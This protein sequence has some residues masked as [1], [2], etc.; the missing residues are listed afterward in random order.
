MIIHPIDFRYGT[1]EMKYIWT[2]EYRL[3]CILRVEISLAQAESRLGII[4]VEAAET[5]TKSAAVVSLKRVKEIESE[6]GHEVMATVKALSEVS[7]SAGRW[8]HFGVSSSDV[9]DTATGLQLKAALKILDEKLRSLLSVLLTR[10]DETK[11]LVCIARTHGQHA[12]PTTY[13]M[14]FAIWASEISRHLDRITELLKRTAVGQ[15]TGAVGTMAAFGKKGIDIQKE[16]MNILGLGC[17][18]VSNQVISRDRYAEYIF[19]LANIATTMDKIGIELRTLQRTEIGEVAEA[20]GRKQIGSSAMPHKRNPVKS[21]QVCGLSRII[22]GM[23]EPALMN[24]TLWDERDL[25]NSSSERI[26]FPE[27]SV[28]TDHC[29]KLTTDILSTLTIN[30]DAVRENLHYLS[31]INLA[32]AV[33]TELTARGA[34]RQTA[35]D[36]IHD[37]CMKAFAEKK[38]LYDILAENSFVIQYLS[39]EEINSLLTPENYIGLAKEQVEA[40]IQK[41]SPYPNKF[42]SN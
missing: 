28:L 40:V 35:F 27:T 39:K 8:V 42:K 12:V 37:E 23:V 21:E 14:R 30:P 2:E 7:G 29:V 36:I 32:E 15:M 3:S 9:L 26:L 13:G 38:A 17:V 41:L 6:I 19:V 25:T 4:P 31:G 22:R 18:D 16:T 24:N 5:I 33:V 10:A 11:E 20:F 34:A 1:S